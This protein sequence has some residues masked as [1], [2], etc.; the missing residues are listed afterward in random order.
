MDWLERQ[1]GSLWLALAVVLGVAEM[2]SL[3]LVLVMLAV[4]RRRRHG[5][6]ARPAPPSS[7]R[8][9]SPAVPRS[10][11]SR[12]C[13]R[14]V[15]KRLHTGP[16]LKL[17]HG[18]LVGRQGVVTAAISGTETGRIRI[19]GEVWSASP[20]DETLTI[21]PGETVE[22]LRS[23]GRPRTSTPSRASSPERL[24]AERE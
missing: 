12:S 5:R 8:C 17:G 1:P 14:R 7:R 10:R 19:D 9:S 24:S 22:V 3:D 6:G 2:L 4:G 21:A 23:A 13:G 20:Y 18:K 11:C 15:V 16:E